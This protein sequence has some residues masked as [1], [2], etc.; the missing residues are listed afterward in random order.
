M[1]DV[2][3]ELEETRAGLRRL[4]E[5]MCEYCEAIRDRCEDCQKED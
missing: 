3:R 2:E 5:L 1:R 4:I